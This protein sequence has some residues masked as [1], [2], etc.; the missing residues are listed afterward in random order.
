METDNEAPSNEL[1]GVLAPDDWMDDF[2]WPRCDLAAGH[3][4]RHQE[5]SSGARW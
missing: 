1:C 2:G 5:A 4:G 3:D